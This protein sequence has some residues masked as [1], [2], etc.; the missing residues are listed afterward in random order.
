MWFLA[1]TLKQNVLITLQFQDHYW[2][3]PDLICVPGPLTVPSLEP[4]LLSTMLLRL[5]TQS[6]YLVCGGLTA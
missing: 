3:M 5:T 2:I 1:H 6:R 4:Q